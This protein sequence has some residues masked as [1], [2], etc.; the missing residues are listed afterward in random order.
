M[1]HSST[2]KYPHMHQPLTRK[3]FLSDRILFAWVK[4]ILFSLTAKQDYLWFFSL[5]LGDPLAID[6]EQTNNPWRVDH[7]QQVQH[8]KRIKSPWTIP[9]SGKDKQQQKWPILTSVRFLICE[10]FQKYNL[11]L[12]P[13][14]TFKYIEELQ[15]LNWKMLLNISLIFFHCSKRIIFE[16][17]RKTKIAR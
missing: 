16:I 13:I 11:T 12:F 8:F 1:C 7:Q 6:I 17:S 15:I 5:S 14:I 2:Q 10:N 3:F 4:W 9:S